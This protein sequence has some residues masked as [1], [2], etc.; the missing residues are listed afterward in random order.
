[1]RTRKSAREKLDNP[2][3]PK[4]VA[5]PERW[6]VRY[7]NGGMLVPSPREV[8]RLMRS[9]RPGELLTVSQIRERL[10][11]EHGV[12]MTCP[13]TTGIFVR[14]AAVAAEEDRREGKRGS[15]PIGA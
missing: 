11:R 14:I 9:V 10:A 13:L 12:D 4:V 5:V 1:M 7:G 3:L 6:Q 8:E 15:S 2:A